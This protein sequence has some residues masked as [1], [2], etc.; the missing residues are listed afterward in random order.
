MQSRNPLNATVLAVNDPLALV[1]F[2]DWPEVECEQLIA[3]MD[4]IP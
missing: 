3:E 2:D 4:E 1:R